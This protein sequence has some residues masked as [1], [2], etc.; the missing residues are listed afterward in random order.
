M[1][2]H[3]GTSKTNWNPEQKGQPWKPSAQHIQSMKETHF[4]ATTYQKRR[5]KDV[6]SMPTTRYRFKLHLFQ[7]A[8]NQLCMPNL[9][10]YLS[11]HSKTFSLGWLACKICL[12]LHTTCK[13]LRHAHFN[14]NVVWFTLA[15][16]T[17]QWKESRSYPQEV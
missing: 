3:R 17:F 7:R 5:Y 16:F 11:E 12:K 2:N 9:T 15:V 4:S 1:E 6:V 8:G 10:K 13:H 14:R